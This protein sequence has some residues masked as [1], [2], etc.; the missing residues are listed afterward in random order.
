MVRNAMHLSTN[1]EQGS[2]PEV[3]EFARRLMGRIDLDPA[4]SPYW[5]QFVRAERYYTKEQNGL[6]LPWEG[7][8]FCNP[9]GDKTGR[10]VQR[11][12]RKLVRDSAHTVASFWVGFNLE[13]LTGLQQFAR[14]PLAPRIWLIVPRRRLCFLGSEG[15]DPTHGNYLAYIP[16][17]VPEGE[18]LE[19][20]PWPEEYMRQHELWSENPFGQAV[21][22]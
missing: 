14:N 5:N 20:G 2:P 13:Q 9:P 16:H 8:V 22:K 15:D 12:W 18:A 17:S 19:H 6:F 10:L 7:C 21:I 1:E 3:I 4:S 11:F